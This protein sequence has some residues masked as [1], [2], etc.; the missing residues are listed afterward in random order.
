MNKN[1]IRLLTCDNLYVFYK[2]F[3]D[4][5]WTSGR[6]K[7]KYH[8]NCYK[9]YRGAFI[10]ED[11]FGVDLCTLVQRIARVHRQFT[12]QTLAAAIRPRG[13]HLQ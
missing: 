8:K 7:V 5:E 1:D 9:T 3:G 13:A 4:T 6:E 11:V 12:L 10:A 2:G